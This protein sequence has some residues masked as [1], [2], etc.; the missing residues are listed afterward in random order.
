MNREPLSVALRYLINGFTALGAVSLL[1][2]KRMSVFIRCFVVDEKLFNNNCRYKSNTL[3]YESAE[4]NGIRTLSTLS[5]TSVFNSIVYP[6]KSST[7]TFYSPRQS[8]NLW[9]TWETL[10]HSKICN[11]RIAN[12]THQNHGTWSH[13][14]RTKLPLAYEKPM[15]ASAE[16]GIRST[17]ILAVQQTE[18]FW[19]LFDKYWMLNPT[20]GISSMP[21]STKNEL[22]QHNAYY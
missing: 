22:L 16:K 9:R 17:A 11:E 20:L 19:D 8:K 7:Q 18:V 12:D 4:K 21:I 15:T 10:F 13:P 14:H 6:N 2:D 5:R 1:M 3:C